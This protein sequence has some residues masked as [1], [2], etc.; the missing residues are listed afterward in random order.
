MDT[1]S[2]SEAGPEIDQPGL[3]RLREAIANYTREKFPRRATLLQDCLAA[4][5]T[6]IT[7]VPDGL[8]SGILAGVNPIYGLYAA[9]GGPI[10][11]GIFSSSSLMIITTT[12]ASSLAAG[13]ALAGL[14]GEA[15]NNA[16]FMMVLLS[17]AIQ[18]VLGLLKMGRVTRFVSYSVMTGFLAGIAVLTILSQLP[19]ITGYEAEG[20]NHIARTIDLL[21]NFDQ[22][23][24]LT[25]ALGALTLVLMITLPRT[26][27][28]NLGTLA[29]IVIPSLLV[30]I[31][32]WEGVQTI[33]DVGEIPQGLPSLY[34]PTLSG[35]TPG[36]IAG[37]ASIAV[38]VLIQGAGVSQS[39]PN[40]K[41]S[42]NRISRDFIG[43]GAANI[44]SGILQGLPVGGSLSTTAVN[45]VSGART[46]WAVIFSGI[47]ML[48]IVL[49]FPDLVSYIIMPA[50]GAVL[51]IASFST[52]KLG[53]MLSIYDTGWSSRLAIIATF[54]TTLFLSIPVAVGF[55]VVLSA[56]LYLNESSA[57][58][59]IVELVQRPDGRIE[60]RKRPKK[61]KSN[62]VTVLDVYG[63]LFYAGART[64]ERLLPAPRG[65]E[66]PVV[67]LRM[68]GHQTVGATLVDILENY[69]DRLGEVN[70][71]LY[72]TGLSDEAYDQIVRTGKLRLTGPVRA[73]GATS[74]IW[75]STRE[76]VTDARAWLVSRRGED[77]VSQNR[78]VLPDESREDE[79]KSE[80]EH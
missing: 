18:V 34:V 16:L 21:V 41:G 48:V 44:A 28:G 59:S 31:F 23:N 12:S 54:L 43:Q 60:E 49:V 39:I 72:L 20:E 29:A 25:F 78:S 27:L 57:D 70:G 10:A 53:D 26:Y 50:L 73:Y 55:G 42:R 33:R 68:R 38:I 80:N 14:S 56:I 37:A 13:Q 63:H 2:K 61:L 6:A 47:A 4:L 40:P 30:V 74:I 77:G 5:N 22:I 46:R 7:S 8:A 17:G 51:I 19:T 75:E 3:S 32:R 11:G 35:I 66:N 65:V 45:V 79:T 64:L 76:A 71:R 67:I 36:I 1:A 15:R 62:A 9:I 52:I 24:W 69:S 58:I